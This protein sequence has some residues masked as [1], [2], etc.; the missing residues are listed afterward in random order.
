[1]AG[2]TV[3]AWPRLPGTVT[4]DADGTVD[5]SV[6]SGFFELLPV[7]P[8]SAIP[9]T[10]ATEIRSRAPAWWVRNLLA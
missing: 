1:M 7:H 8:E 6:D 4:G 3:G 5:V 2:G 9:T 10:M